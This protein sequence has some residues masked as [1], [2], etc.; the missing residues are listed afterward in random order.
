MSLNTRLLFVV[1]TT[2]LLLL[3][4]HAKKESI[5]EQTEPAERE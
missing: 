4:C 1:A 5:A 3:G 2:A